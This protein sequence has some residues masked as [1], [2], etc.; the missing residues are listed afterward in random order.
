MKK[1]LKK[2]G[3]FILWINDRSAFNK[4]FGLTVLNQQ[5]LMLVIYWPS[6]RDFVVCLKSLFADNCRALNAIKCLRLCDSSSS[7]ILRCSLSTCWKGSLWGN[8]HNSI[9]LQF[10][11]T[12]FNWKPFKSIIKDDIIFV[13]S[14]LQKVNLKRFSLMSKIVIRRNVK[15][16]ILTFF[17]RTNQVS[18]MHIFAYFWLK[19]SRWFWTVLASW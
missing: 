10:I 5:W 3:N 6:C 19:I 16:N 12:L 11:S 2:Y 15:L 1:W 4:C 17:G 7:I 8:W 18:Y 13:I 9:S 14:H